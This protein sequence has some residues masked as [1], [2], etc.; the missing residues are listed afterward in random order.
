MKM[1]TIA[2]ILAA[3]LL[4]LSA[5]GGGSDDGG[6]GNGGAGDSG[7]TGADGTTTVS[8]TAAAGAPIVGIVNIKGADGATASS[9]IEMDG[10]YS[11]DVSDVTAPYILYAEGSVNGK[12]ISIYS[13]AVAAGTIN[14]TPITDFILRNALGA[15]AEE[16]YDNWNSDQVSQSSLNAAQSDVRG[17]I[18]PL[19]TAAGVSAEADLIS[20]AFDTDHAGMDAVLDALDITY[21]DTM[22][23]I[24]NN[25]TGSSYTDDITLTDDGTGLPAS[26]QEAS[27]T[28]LTD[29]Q[30]MDL[31][32]QSLTALYADSRPSPAELTDW[33][34]S[35]VAED[36]LDWGSN[37]TQALDDWLY[38]DDGP[39]VDL[40]I[41]AAVVEPMEVAGTPYTKGYWIRIFYTSPAESGNTVTS[42]V[43]DGTGWLWY[44]NRKWL[45]DDGP[46]SE[47]FKYVS[48]TGLTWFQTGFSLYMDDGYNYA[49]DQGVRSAVVTGPGLPAQ[50]IILEHKFPVN[51]L[52]LYG[53]E[54]LYTI[55]DDAILSDIADN[56]QYLTQLCPESAADLAGGTATCSVLHSFTTINMR[57]PVPNSELSSSLFASLISP[58]SHEASELNFGGEITIE[59]T[60]P[61]NTKSNHIGLSWWSSGTKYELEAGLEENSTSV[62]LDATGLPAPDG[63]ARLFINIEDQYEREFNMGWELQ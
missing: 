26:D 41:S 49:Y 42:M 46:E 51:E 57:P 6:S 35:N 39:D 16:A 40:V 31:V 32:W 60:K 24:T 29:H 54:G 13:A 5:C 1:R 47:A 11:I 56:A 50:G 14:I 4:F 25:L 30:A 27:Q 9:P 45:E 21:S 63:Y 28:A 44:G 43:Y 48:S 52:G 62:T 61:A 15:Q 33:F 36:Y 17:Q 37:R 2:P 3:L 58:S 55:A 19:L 53:S 12:T 8:G 38:D 7:G 18:A 22:A 23:T 10:Y 34:H 20:T 59:W